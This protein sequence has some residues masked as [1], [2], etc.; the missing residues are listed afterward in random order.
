MVHQTI[1]RS[2]LPQS[3]LKLTVHYND[4]KTKLNKKRNCHV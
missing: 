2:I 1:E 4:S 3:Y